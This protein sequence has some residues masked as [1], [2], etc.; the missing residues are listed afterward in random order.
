MSLS[1][2]SDEEISELLTK[3]GIKHGPI[4]EST[5]G[6]YEKKL[7]RLMESAAVKSSPDKTFYREEEEE[8]T[9]ITYH[10][11]VRHEAYGD[12]LKRRGNANTEEDEESEQETEDPP[13]QVTHRTANHSAVRS[14]EPLKKSGG[15]MWKFT[16]LLLLLVVLAAAYYAYCQMV[17]I[18]E[19]NPTGIQ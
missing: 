11:P 2:K 7:A 4:V 12:S 1:E 3:F 9:Y 8:V 14:N 19:K 13:I 15:C 18:E 10:T 16:R 17:D 5:R 6:L